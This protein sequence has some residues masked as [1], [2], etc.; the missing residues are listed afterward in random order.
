VCDAGLKSLGMDHGNPTIDGAKVWFCSDEH[1]TFSSD[2]ESK[3]PLAAKVGDRVRVW[4][5]HIDPTLAYHDRLH[6]ADGDAIVD[7]WP[8]DLRGW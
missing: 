6:L 5:A 7:V 1:V 4:P 3:H 8:I 2:T